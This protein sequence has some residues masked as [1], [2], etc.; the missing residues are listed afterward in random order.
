MAPSQPGFGEVAGRP[1]DG[2]RDG[3][4]GEHPERQVGVPSGV[5]RRRGSVA[6]ERLAAGQVRHRVDPRERGGGRERELPAGDGAGVAH[7]RGTGVLVLEVAVV[8]R[9]GVRLAGVVRRLDD[10]VALGAADGAIRLLVARGRADGPALDAGADDA[11]TAEDHQLVRGEPVE[12]GLHR[13]R[14]AL[15]GDQ[16]QRAGSQR[17]GRAAGERVREV[18][19]DREEG[20]GRLGEVRAGDLRGAGEAVGAV[21]A[22]ELGR[23]LAQL[24][25]GVGEDR[26]RAADDDDAGGL[27]AVDLV[28]RLGRHAGWDR[29]AAPGRPDRRRPGRPPARRRSRCRWRRTRRRRPGRRSRP[30][31]RP[32]WRSGWHR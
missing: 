11:G 16:Q 7:L 9:V 12:L 26:G 19:A 4:A 30:T 2:A 25:L 17:S 32:R 28:E 31:A 6:V 21:H 18:G 29:S 5:D 15:L 23:E 22:V 8:P 14:D 1:H 27:Q 10:V 20:G 13:G 24:L 3:L